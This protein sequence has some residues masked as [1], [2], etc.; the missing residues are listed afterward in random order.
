[1]LASLVS[2]WLAVRPPRLTIGV[3]PADVGLAVEPLTIPTADGLRLAGWVAV[4]PGR[5]AV[6]LLHGY[7]AE[8]RDL[9]P[10]AAT[11]HRHFSVLLIDLRYFGQSEGRVTTLGYRERQDLERAVDV[12]EARGLGP[13]GVF[14]FSL[15]GAVALLAAAEDPR[16]RAVAAYAPFA[17]LRL[18]GRDLYRGLWILREPLVG[19]M[20]LWSRLF[21]GADIT[22][23][24]PVEAA[25]RLTIPVL[26][27][28]SRA[29]DQIP[30]HHAR[31][32]ARALGANRGAQFVFV[33]QGYHGALDPDLQQRI[34]DFFQ[35]SLRPPPS[36]RPGS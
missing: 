11:L 19:L 10:L 27:I 23:P 22:R 28:H 24:A 30:F 14:G 5:P 20:R 1:V 26:L 17:D 6:I 36:A 35:G 18:L 16:I 31:R 29:D 12:L 2:F 8:K 33:D 3:R 7:P 13:V 21:L 32:L 34:A 25:R 4:R 9:L 15:G